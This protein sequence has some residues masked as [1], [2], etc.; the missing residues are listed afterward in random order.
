VNTHPV[1]EI[2]ICAQPFAKSRVIEID[3]Y[4]A[5][6]VPDY[7]DGGRIELA[8]FEDTTFTLDDSGA[9]FKLVS[10]QLLTVLIV[11]LG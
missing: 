3:E 9:I 7:Q 8:P 5:L 11:H 2:K 1:A 4:F 10:N 6:P